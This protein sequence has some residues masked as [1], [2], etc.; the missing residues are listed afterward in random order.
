[1]AAPG[2]SV[3]GLLPLRNEAGE[4]TVRSGPGLDTRDRRPP[5]PV[6]SVRGPARSERRVFADIR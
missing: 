5:G 3:R 4:K 1:M 6:R 2:P